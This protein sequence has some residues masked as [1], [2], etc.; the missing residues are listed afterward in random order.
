MDPVGQLLKTWIRRKPVSVHSGIAKHLPLVF[1]MHG[2]SY[3]LFSGI[4][5]QLFAAEYAWI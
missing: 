5:M 3:N 2:K 4:L 1:M